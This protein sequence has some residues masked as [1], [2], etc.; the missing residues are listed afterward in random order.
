[1]GIRFSD[2]VISDVMRFNLFFIMGA[3]YGKNIVDVVQK[4]IK[5][6]LFGGFTALVVIN[7]VVYNM[8]ITSELLL[9]FTKFVTSGLGICVL[10]SLGNV[11]SDNSVMQY[12]GKSSLP[13]YVL[14]G[15]AIAASRIVLGKIYHGGDLWGIMPMFV[16]TLG[17]TLIPLLA[18]EMALRIWKFD[19]F[20]RPEKYIR[21]E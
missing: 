1:M 6:Y 17:G 12:L 11:F 13:I 16:C 15:F 3:Y 20:F 5:V 10:I 7:V 2:S 21:I 19:F 8:H 18:Y 14:Q 4:H 9:R